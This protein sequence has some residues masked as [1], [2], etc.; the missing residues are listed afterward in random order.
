MSIKV[1]ANKCLKFDRG[2]HDAKGNLM[3]EKTQIGFCTLP[4]WVGSTQYFKDAIDDGSLQL[5]GGA[6]EMSSAARIADLEKQLSEL[7]LLIDKAPTELTMSDVEGDE[8]DPEGD[9]DLNEGS[10]EDQAPAETASEKRKRL[11]STRG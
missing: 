6:S 5:V 11:R 9:V 2:E 7:K 10:E 4:D 3:V 1:L 8:T